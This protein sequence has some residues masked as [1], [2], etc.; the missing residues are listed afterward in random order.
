MESIDWSTLR[1]RE[2]TPS[3][4]EAF[5]AMLRR[6]E[7][8]AAQQAR[9]NAR[10]QGNGPRDAYNRADI[11]KRDGWTCWI[12]RHPVDRNLRWPH[13]ECA[14]VDHVIALRDGGTDTLNN[15]ACAHNGC[16]ADRNN[17]SDPSTL[18]RMRQRRL[19]RRGSSKGADA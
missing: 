4:T 10:I 18:A 2:L 3:E 19:A 6:R 11:F 9:R 7:V 5:A 13:P 17:V 8:R 16:N 15:V 14:V 12:C 1:V